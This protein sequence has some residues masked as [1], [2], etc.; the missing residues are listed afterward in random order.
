MKRLGKRWYALLALLILIFIGIRLPASLAAAALASKSDGKIKLAAVT[1]TL[2]HGQGQL[3]IGDTA[4]W[5]SLQWDWQAG[6]L[7]HGALGFLIAADGGHAAL[8]L[9]P[10]AVEIA[11]MDIS[12]PATPILQLDPRAAGFGLTGRLRLSATQLRVGKQPSGSLALDW[13]QAGSQRIPV[14]SELG[15]YRANLT[16]NG[17]AWKVQLTT[18]SGPFQL[19]GEGEWHATTGLAAEIV[20]KAAPGS[21]GQLAPLLN[22][23][24]PGEPQQERRM[25]FNFR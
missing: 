11:D 6:E 24:G 21:E 22:Q 7:L 20:A 13:Q 12:A 4:V 2:W 25:R 18:L 10:T 5:Q 14:P 17:D 23:M 9:R 16:P 8:H 1:G 19:S 15:N 3:V